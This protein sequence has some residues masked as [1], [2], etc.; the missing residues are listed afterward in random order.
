MV[1][2]LYIMNNLSF[3]VCHAAY[4]HVYSVFL[5]YIYIYIDISQLKD[6]SGYTGIDLDLSIQPLT[7][8]ESAQ[9]IQSTVQKSNESTPAPTDT[10]PLAVVTEVQPNL[11]TKRSDGHHKPHASHLTETAEV[12]DDTKSSKLL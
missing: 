6:T 3:Y 5:L 1:A 10:Q 7:L 9:N 4:V 8:A 2:A 11:E 12:K